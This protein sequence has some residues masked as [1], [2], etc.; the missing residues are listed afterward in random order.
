MTKLEMEEEDKWY[1][2][3]KIQLRELI[4]HDINLKLVEKIK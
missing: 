4:E 2:K 1:K 3:K